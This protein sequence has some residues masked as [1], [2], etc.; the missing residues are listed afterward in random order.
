MMIARKLLVPFLCVVFFAA[1]IAGS[2]GQSD[3]VK[4]GLAE[5]DGVSGCVAFDNLDIQE[6]E[7]IKFVTVAGLSEQQRVLLGTIGARMNLPSPCSGLESPHF[8]GYIYSVTLSQGSF[9]AEDLAIAIRESTSL[10][11]ILEGE[12]IG[13]SSNGL[14]TLYFRS[15]ATGEGLYLT[16]WAGKPL[17]GKRLWSKYY[18]LGYDVDSDCTE[19]D[20][21]RKSRIIKNQK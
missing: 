6:G 2:A 7:A 19:L 15:C 21:D 14:P 4:F 13:L 12:S 10:K 3:T 16:A 11:V 20:F 9:N 18:Y 17:E 1:P 8:H 5:G